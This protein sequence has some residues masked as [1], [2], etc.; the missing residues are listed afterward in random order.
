VIV[1]QEW[2]GLDPGIKTV[3]E[4]LADEGFV[5]LAPDL[6]HGELAGHDDREGE[7]R[8]VGLRRLLA[9][10]GPHVDLQL[11]M[12]RSRECPIRHQ[13]DR[14]RLRHSTDLGGRVALTPQVAAGR[15][16]G[17]CIQQL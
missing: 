14:P 5:A 6:Y 2:W 3:C 11:D 4:K 12:A 9:G 13:Q 1:V 7:P 17:A 10:L 15:D 8:R 16:L